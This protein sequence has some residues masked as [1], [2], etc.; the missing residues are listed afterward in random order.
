MIPQ[1][2]SKFYSLKNLAVLDYLDHLANDT[3]VLYVDAFD[4]LIQGHISALQGSYCEKQWEASVA[5]FLKDH[6]AGISVA[7]GKQRDVHLD[8]SLVHAWHAEPLI[9][10]AEENCFPYPNYWEKIGDSILNQGDAYDAYKQSQETYKMKDGR[11]LNGDALC[12]EQER[13]ASGERRFLNSGGVVG[14][15]G[16]L[17][18]LLHLTIPELQ[19]GEAMDQATWQLV[20]LQRP[21]LGVLDQDATIF[22][23]MHVPERG[24]ATLQ[25]A[26]IVCD[27]LPVRIGGRTPLVLHFNGNGKR[28]YSRCRMRLLETGFERKHCEHVSNLDR[29]WNRS[30]LMRKAL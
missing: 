17:R 13:L 28:H 9:F 19:R 29:F 22:L 20:W 23:N 8:A 5:R 10:S 11:I 15:V 14:R 24:A 25:P 6:I 3:L 4:V 18:E 21:D 16:R 27:Q 7:S 12:F 2:I 26:G 1:L 30:S